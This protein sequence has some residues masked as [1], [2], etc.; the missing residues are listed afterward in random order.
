[1]PIRQNVRT[2]TGGDALAYPVQLPMIGTP[3]GRGL[4]SG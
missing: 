3:Y 4:D 2:P 1:M